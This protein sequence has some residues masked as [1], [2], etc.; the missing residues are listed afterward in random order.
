MAYKPTSDTKNFPFER[1]FSLK[2]TLVFDQ[3]IE[4]GEEDEVNC[5][6]EQVEQLAV[7]PVTGKKLKA[8]TP[9]VLVQEGH[10]RG[11]IL[12][13]EEAPPVI[14]STYGPSLRGFNHAFQVTFAE[15]RSII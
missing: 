8:S 14:Y 2:W 9:I 13:E 15:F 1:Q 3:T 12:S 4:S 10:K 6:K 7:L 11:K 5:T